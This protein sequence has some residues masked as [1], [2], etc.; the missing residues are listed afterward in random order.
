VRNKIKPAT[1]KLFEQPLRSI[2]GLPRHV[3]ELIGKEVAQSLV[4]KRLG[5]TMVVCFP[6][7]K[8][9]VLWRCRG[10]FG[11]W[12]RFRDWCPWCES[13]AKYVR[14]MKQAEITTKARNKKRARGGGR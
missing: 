12:K 6:D 3:R 5:D 4:G 10:C 9:V 1:L 11:W 13:W 2:H 8:T 7:G 14:E